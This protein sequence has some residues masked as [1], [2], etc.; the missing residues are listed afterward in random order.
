MG[1]ARTTQLILC[2]ALGED[3]G[4]EQW[5]PT[6][7]VAADL[8]STIV[9]TVYLAVFSVG[10]PCPFMSLGSNDSV[11]TELPFLLFSWHEGCG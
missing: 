11:L 1:P 8:L 3:Y 2:T 10:L 9:G 7:R 6:L 5:V 4:L